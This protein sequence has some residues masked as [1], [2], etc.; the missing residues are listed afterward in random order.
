VGDFLYSIFWWYTLYIITKYMENETINTPEIP[1]P[2]K[3]KKSIY[4]GFI[5]LV[6]I[7]LLAW[8]LSI[9]SKPAPVAKNP[10][11]IDIRSTIYQHAT[12][13]A[14]LT[15]T[16]AARVIFDKYFSVYKTMPDCSASALADFKL[17]S[18]G[19]PE[20]RVGGFTIPVV[21]DLKP[22][23]MSETKWISASSSEATIDGEWIRGKKG[24]FSI[25]QIDN[26][27]QLVI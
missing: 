18:L 27:Y 20:P 15:E 7:T 1:T 17:I 16:Q 13:S 4:I 25:S 2:E 9:L 3:S 12:S 5:I 26:L 23:S 11:A 22:L 24:T 21:F 6:V 14:P 19:K 8:G 10:C